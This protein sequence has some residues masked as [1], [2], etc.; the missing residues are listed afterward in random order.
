[1]AIIVTLKDIDEAIDSLSYKSETTL[2]CK[3]IRAVRNLYPD[4]SSIEALKSIDTEELVKVVWDTGDD[5]ELIKIKR[6]SFSSIKSSVNNDLKKLYQKGNNPQGIIIG[7]N[8]IFDISDDAKNKALS[9]IADIF[10]EKGI[11]T[12]SKITEILAALSD[13]LANAISSTNPE[14]AREEID[15]LKTLMTGLSGKFGVPMPESIDQKADEGAGLKKLAGITDILKDKEIDAKSK[16][17]KIMEA[18]KETLSEAISS[19]G[20]DLGSEEAEQLKKLFGDLSGAMQTAL[21]K[22]SGAGG[23]DDLAGV[24]DMLKQQSPETQGKVSNIMNA[25]NEMLTDAVAATAA[26]LNNEEIEKIKNLFGTL[27]EKVKSALGAGCGLDDIGIEA[28]SGDEA[29]EGVADEDVVDEIVEEI[30]EEGAEEIIEVVDQVLEDELAAEEFEE[31]EVSGEE[32]YEPDE[33]LEDIPLEADA[34][35]EEI[36]GELAA[37]E[38]VEIVEEEVFDDE[39]VESAADGEIIE[40]TAAEEVSGDDLEFAEEE[41]TDIV[42]AEDEQA[43]QLEAID[44]EKLDYDEIIEVDDSAALSDEDLVTEEVM[45]AEAIAEE[46]LAA[47][48][49]ISEVVAEDD[50]EELEEVEVV[51][52]EVGAEE[53]EIID[54]KDLGEAVDEDLRSKADVLAELAAAAKALDKLGPDL[55][56]SIY[57]EKEIKEKA[58]LLSE[59]FDRYLSVREKFFN[60]HILIK[61]GNYLVGASN[62]GRSELSEQIVDLGEFYIGKFPVTN[63]LFE[64]FVEKTGY[65]TTAEKYGYGMVYVPRMQKVKNARNGAESF[66][67]NTQLQYKKVPGACWYRPSG[68]TSTLY[69]KRTHP[70][71]QVSFEDA[72]AFAAWTGKRIPTEKEWEAAARTSHSYLY[73]WGNTWQDDACNLEKSLLGDTAPVDQ[74]VKFANEYEVADTLGNVLEWTLDLWRALEQEEDEEAYVVKGASWISDSPVSLADRQPVYKNVSSNILGFRCIAI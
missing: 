45:D 44:A 4:D 33:G 31:V 6:K 74:Y 48:D 57:S 52:E 56:N 63:A 73:P 59:E 27:S 13:I 55:S 25:V 28:G 68:P 38:M 11:D 22:E 61:G 67:W 43:G 20:Q 36:E 42:E 58:K 60:Q 46:E 21:A 72:C 50:L 26:G 41:L 37:D 62:R 12:S 2:K 35:T 9:S 71:V 54:E 14:E 53:G 66:V 69:V 17:N 51:E 23:G 39:F 32:E 24:T 47:D 30:E 70:V 29:G 64:I 16:M 40:E 15:R 1:V 3:L 65:I 19:A 7:H 18:V 34:E 10:R 8:N 5:P 49:A